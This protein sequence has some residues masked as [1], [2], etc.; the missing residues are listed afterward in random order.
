[1]FVFSLSFVF[2]FLLFRVL[3]SI[4]DMRDPSALLSQ[5]YAALSPQGLWLSFEPKCTDD[6]EETVKLKNAKLLLNCSLHVCLP[7]AL[8]TPSTQENAN[9]PDLGGIGYRPSVAKQ[10]CQQAG[11]TRFKVREAGA[12]FGAHF[13]NCYEVRI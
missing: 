4:H 6:V 12:D 7:S 10:L 13:M 2:L 1:M 3:D 11:F 8:S 9:G 5:L